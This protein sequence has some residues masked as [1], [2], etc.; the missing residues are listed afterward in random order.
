MELVPTTQTTP[1]FAI[2]FTLVARFEGDPAPNHLTPSYEN[3]IVFVPCPPAI[4]LFVELA[5]PNS[6]SNAPVGNPFVLALDCVIESLTVAAE[7]DGFEKVGRPTVILSDTSIEAMGIED[8][9][10]P[11]GPIGPVAPV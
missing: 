1:L 11:V 9:N 3:A 8:K 6:Y 4:H 2:E 7:G 5:T 10:R